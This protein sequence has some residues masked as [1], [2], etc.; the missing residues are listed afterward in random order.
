MILPDY[1]MND[2][3]FSIDAKNVVNKQFVFEIVTKV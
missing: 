1:Q 3:S 2:N